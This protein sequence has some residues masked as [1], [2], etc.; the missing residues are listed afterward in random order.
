MERRRAHERDPDR[1]RERL[2]ERYVQ[3]FDRGDLETVDRILAEG[4][5]DPEL[6][7]QL[8]A[9]NDALA[10]EAG[11]NTFAEDS[12][13]V[14]HLLYTHLPSAHPDAEPATPPPLTVGDVA[15]RLQADEAT[16][17]R[18]PAADRLVNQQLRARTEPLPDQVTG[19]AIAALARSLSVTASA[20]Y[21]E[22]FRRTALMLRLQQRTAASTAMAARRAG[23]RGAREPRAGWRTDADARARD[24]AGEGDA[25]PAPGR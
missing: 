2:L 10:E 20:R 5:R 11:L 1:W 16:G 17:R 21:W 12:R 13:L 14:R 22:E 23:R 19:P 8:Q 3:A 6:D 4:A 15:A 7:R 25:E 24:A 18:L 9:I